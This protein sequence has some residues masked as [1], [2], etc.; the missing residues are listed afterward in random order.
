MATAR[1]E[2]LPAAREAVVHDHSPVV[3][4]AVQVEP[5]LVHP[6]LDGLVPCAAVESCTTAPTGAVPVIVS[7]VS[8]VRLSLDDD[9][10]SEASAR[11]G[12]D[13]D[14]SA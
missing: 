5:V 7:V 2:Y 9:P 6:S 12:A 8:E 10:L 4:L 11:S 13:T 3:L 14:G 1:T